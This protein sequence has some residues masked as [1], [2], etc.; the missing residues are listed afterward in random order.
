MQEINIDDLNEIDLIE[1]NI[2]EKPKDD[3]ILCFKNVFVKYT[4]KTNCALNN[5]SFEVFRNQK[6]AICGRTGSGKSSI[7]NCLLKLYD[8]TQGTIFF[9]GTSTK[10]IPAK[11]L[12]SQIVAIY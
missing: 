7:I 5:V 9:N 2:D 12:R 8:A 3:K 6:V 1:I 10:S 11:K 4:G